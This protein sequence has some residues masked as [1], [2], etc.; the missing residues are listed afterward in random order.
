MYELYIDKR[1][2]TAS[3]LAFTSCRPGDIEYSGT[4]GTLLI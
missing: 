4:S 2:H 1:R 3:L